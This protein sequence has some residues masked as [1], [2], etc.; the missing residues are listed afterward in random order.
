[1]NNGTQSIVGL[2]IDLLWLDNVDPLKNSY[3]ATFVLEFEWTDDRL[4]WSRV[5]VDSN[6]DLDRSLSKLFRCSS[7]VEPFQEMIIQLNIFICQHLIYGILIWE[8]FK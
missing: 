8:H 2:G 5:W 3:H 7:T 4:K 6:E 1:M